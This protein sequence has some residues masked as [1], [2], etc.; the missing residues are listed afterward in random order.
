LPLRF[1]LTLP[2]FG[3]GG[4]RPAP[5]TAAQQE[6]ARVKSLSP[7]SDS[8]TRRRGFTSSSGFGTLPGGRAM[9]TTG[10]TGLKTQL[11]Q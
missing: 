7:P 1:N 3:G 8:P 9:P 6:A 10:G 5:Q 4:S 11:G 2:G